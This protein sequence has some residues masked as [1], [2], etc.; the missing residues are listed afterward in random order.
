MG[1]YANVAGE[2]LGADLSLGL[3]GEYHSDFDFI[4]A[5]HS[6]VKYR[7]EDLGLDVFSR[8][9]TGFRAPSLLESEAFAGFNNQLANPDLDPEF[10]TTYELGVEQEI[11]DQHTFRATAYAHFLTHA[12]G[13]EVLSTDPVTYVNTT[14][15]NNT[16]GTSE[17]FGLETSFKGEI[18]DNL[19]YTIAWNYSLRNEL[20]M[21]PR[22]TVSAD[23][24]YSSEN[25]VLG[26]GF[27][28]RSDA[29][30][31][32]PRGP[33]SRE[34]D[35][36]IEFRVYGAWQVTENLKL[37]ARVENLLDE[38]YEINPFAFDYDPVTFTQS[39]REDLARGRALFIE[40][41]TQW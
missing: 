12:I 23:I 32:A 5:L 18:I 39:E 16:S 11:S 17:I 25:W 22:N 4:P 9:A 27:S 14:I 19:N 3:R 33:F 2:V 24:N 1:I 40:L 26:A 15:N 28:H 8:A 6:S 13:S 35:G 31:D 37:S 34:I 21:L 30:F 41:S 36:F 7:F 10:F 38:K 20:L 29:T